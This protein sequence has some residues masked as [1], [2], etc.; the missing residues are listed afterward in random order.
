MMAAHE[1][2]PTRT[3]DFGP[4]GGCTLCPGLNKSL[5]FPC[6]QTPPL[7]SIHTRKARCVPLACVSLH[8]LLAIYRYHNEIHQNLILRDDADAEFLRRRN[9]LWSDLARILPLQERTTSSAR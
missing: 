3:Y 5:L 8:M 1:Q 7:L 4:N 9:A 2:A 6:L